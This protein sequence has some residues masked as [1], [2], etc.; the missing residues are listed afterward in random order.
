MPVSIFYGRW[1][2]P[3]LSFMAKRRSAG[4]V[5]GEGLFAEVK[6]RTVVVIDDLVS[7]GTTLLRVAMAARKNGA[8]QVYSAATHGLFTS[9]AALVL[10]DPALDRVVITNTVPPF[11]LDPELVRSKVD[12]IDTA[13]IMAETIQRLHRGGS[14]TELLGP[15]D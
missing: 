11:R 2:E 12:V 9:K 10:A 13:G 7:S 14:I 1:A 15:E 4:V 8:K 5:S 6:G 3:T